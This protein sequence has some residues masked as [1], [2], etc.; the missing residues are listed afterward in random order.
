MENM[1]NNE[2]KRDLIWVAT[3][4]IMIMAMAVI[5]QILLMEVEEN[6][7]SGEIAHRQKA[8]ILEEIYTDNFICVNDFIDKCFEQ[9]KT[10]KPQVIDSCKNAAAFACLVSSAIRYGSYFR[11]EGKNERGNKEMDYS[12]S[13]PF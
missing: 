9:G 6:K 11:K 3:A 12:F 10:E 13:I 4:T 1:E 5:C 8:A 7:S 2:E